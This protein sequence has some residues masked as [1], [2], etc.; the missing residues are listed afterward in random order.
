[1]VLDCWWSWWC[2]MSV[3][4]GA[5]DLEWSHLSS[6]ITMRLGTLL[7][8]GPSFTLGRLTGSPSW[9]SSM[10]W[11][12]TFILVS[13]FSL[14]VRA[15][16]NTA[17][18]CHEESARQGSARCRLPPRSSLCSPW[19]SFLSAHV[20]ILHAEPPKSCC[21]HRQSDWSHACHEVGSGLLTWYPSPS[22]ADKIL[23]LAVVFH[24]T[25][26]A[27]WVLKA[28]LSKS[29]WEVWTDLQEALEN[30]FASPKRL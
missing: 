30:Q 4:S 2:P 8:C 9:R 23:M 19:P 17:A 5:S 16:P 24:C 21:T 27:A 3:P 1:M 22:T 6:W 29:S 26:K 25:A 14:C 15:R 13:S 18:E 7:S 20:W 10:Q 11:Q 28:T 12:K